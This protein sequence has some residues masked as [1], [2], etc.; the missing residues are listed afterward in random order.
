MEARQ[1]FIWITISQPYLIYIYIYGRSVSDACSDDYNIYK[2]CKIQIVSDTTIK[3]L[4]FWQTT[5]P[6]HDL[7]STSA[8][9]IAGTNKSISGGCGIVAILGY[10]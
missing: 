1:K 9:G 2:T 3:P 6:V 10:K 5:M 8:S 7:N 4:M